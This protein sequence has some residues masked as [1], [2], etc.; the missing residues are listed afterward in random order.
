M[1]EN[2]TRVMVGP[3][4]SISGTAPVAVPLGEYEVTITL[5]EVVTL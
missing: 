4:H 5:I 3:D 2:R 1:A